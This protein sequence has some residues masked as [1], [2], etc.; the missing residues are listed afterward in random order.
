MIEAKKGSDRRGGATDIEKLREFRN[1]LGY[2][3]AVFLRFQTGEN[4]GIEIPV[5]I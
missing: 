2:R 4:A 1:Q 3:H 5:W